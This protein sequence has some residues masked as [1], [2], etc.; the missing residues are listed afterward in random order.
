MEDKIS[1]QHALYLENLHETYLKKNKD[2]GSSFDDSLDNFGS[3]A[4]VVRISDKYN[5]LVQLTASNE[6]A[7]VSDEAVEDTLLDMANYAIMMAMWLE[8]QKKDDTMDRAFERLFP[9]RLK[10]FK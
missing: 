10:S 9:N 4:G 2:Y 7:K 6:E 8:R 5:R 1:K 3:I